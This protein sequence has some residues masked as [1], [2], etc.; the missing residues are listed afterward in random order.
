MSEELKKCP[1]CGSLYGYFL[2]DN[3]YV[4]PEC[5]FEW[6]PNKVSEE[7]NTTVV[8]A[9]GNPLFDGDSVIIIKDL[10]LKGYSK[11]LK[12]GTK[13][14]SIRLVDGDHNIHCKIDGF[15]TVFLK[16]EFVKKV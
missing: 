11:P 10:P 16:S 9:N 12:S 13:V 14:K 3:V 4:C 1:N 5:D 15:G 7:N 2:K 6:D 8:D